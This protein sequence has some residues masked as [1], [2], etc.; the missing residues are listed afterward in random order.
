[1]WENCIVYTPYFIYLFSGTT[2]SKCDE[3]V[4]S[5][6]QATFSVVI[7]VWRDVCKVNLMI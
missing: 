3:K 4:L 1:M 5:G 2:S 6:N 7:G